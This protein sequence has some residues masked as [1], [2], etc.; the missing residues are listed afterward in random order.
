M[1]LPQIVTCMVSPGAHLVKNFESHSR[2]IESQFKKQEV[3][4][5]KMLGPLCDQVDKRYS[6]VKH[7]SL[8]EYNIMHRSTMA[9]RI[10]TEITQTGYPTKN[11]FR[12]INWSLCP[13]RDAAIYVC[14]FW[15]IF[16]HQGCRTQR[17][18]NHCINIFHYHH[19]HCFAG[20]CKISHE[21]CLI[22]PPI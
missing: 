4:T 12:S 15:W 1:I 17:S 2:T 9:R 22:Q 3:L 11:I 13:T 10:A 21:M 14:A 20:T 8:K 6:F 18:Q 19:D 7:N 5:W 16:M